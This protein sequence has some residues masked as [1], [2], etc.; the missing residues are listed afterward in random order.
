[1]QKI[2]LA[3]LLL[4]FGVSG[5]SAQQQQAA[6]RAATPPASSTADFLA[7]GFEIKGVINNTY[8][9]VQKG[10]R[11]FLCGSPDNLTWANWAEH[12]RDAPC[13]SM[14]RSN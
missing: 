14:T 5:A 13:K 3:A 8:L 7:Q 1:M 4:A 2:V 10:D 12:T 6:A 9:L 11:A